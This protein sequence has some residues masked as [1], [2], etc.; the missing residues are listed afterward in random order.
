MIEAIIFDKDGTL[1]DFNA[2]WS[3]A[4]LSLLDGLAKDDLARRAAISEAIGFDQETQRFLPGAV[5]VTG[6]EDAMIDALKSAVPDLTRSDVKA[7]YEEISQD[8]V[9]RPVLELAPYFAR[10][11]AAGYKLG[12][13]TNDWEASASMQLAAS[14][15]LPH[16]SFL[17]GCDSG[18]GHKPEP[19]QMLAF[20]A[21]TGVKPSKT[22]VVGDS[23]YDLE[24]AAA[25]GMRA[26]G[27]LTGAATERELAP[28]AE[29]VLP[30]IGHLERW[31]ERA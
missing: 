10:L 4:M 9:Q 31:L 11:K 29:A 13:V 19:G 26:V 6:P 3:G 8:T 21:K 14:G 28:F 20:A 17:S 30:D 5:G 23:H 25:A 27:V 16:L 15:V 12:V 24:A 7:V 18:H 2:T 1:T 22:M